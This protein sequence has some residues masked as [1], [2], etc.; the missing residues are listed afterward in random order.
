MARARPGT[1]WHP[2]AGRI[3]RGARHVLASPTYNPLRRGSAGLVSGQH[4]EPGA[5]GC[6]GGGPGPRPEAAC[7]PP[8]VWAGS[9]HPTPIPG[10]QHPVRSRTWRSVGPD[11]SSITMNVVPSTTPQS[12]TVTSRGWLSRAVFRASRSNRATNPPSAAYGGLRIFTATSRPKTSSLARHTVAMPPVPS[13]SP[14]PTGRRQ[15]RYRSPPWH[16]PT[17]FARPRSS[18]AYPAR[19]RQ[20]TVSSARKTENL[21]ISRAQGT[22]SRLRTHQHG[23]ATNAATKAAVILSPCHPP[24]AGRRQRPVW[25][26]QSSH[27]GG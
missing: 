27:R 10:G 9:H 24:A 17:P 16:S 1:A 11:T 25:A 23:A 15:P 7:P 22:V 20:P 19:R 14:A 12:N 8:P 2:G 5:A 3:A 13:A 4:G 18:F 21:P 6:V 26:G